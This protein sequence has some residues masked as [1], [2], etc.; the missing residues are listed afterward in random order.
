MFQVKLVDLDEINI[1]FST[2]GRFWVTRKRSVWVAWSAHK[3]K[4]TFHRSV[5][6]KQWILDVREPWCSELRNFLT[7]HLNIITLACREWYRRIS[8]SFNLSWLV[9]TNRDQVSRDMKNYFTCSS[10]EERLGNIVLKHVAS[11]LL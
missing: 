3:T 11:I 7:I 6:Y 10:E 5:E 9:P 1:Q 4:F 8:Q 2:I